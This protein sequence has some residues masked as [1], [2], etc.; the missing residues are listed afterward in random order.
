MFQPEFGPDFLFRLLRYGL[1][2]VPL[3][4][5]GCLGVL[6]PV[7]VD[8]RYIPPSPAR[9]LTGKPVFLH[10]KDERRTNALARD[11]G[12]TVSVLNKVNAVIPGGGGE[13]PGA[14]ETFVT[15]ARAAYLAAASRLESLGH[16]VLMQREEALHDAYRLVLYVYS[17]EVS[18]GDQAYSSATVG[19]AL[20]KIPDAIYLVDKPVTAERPLEE[21]SAIY[22]PICAQGVGLGTAPLAAGEKKASADISLSRALERAVNALDI[23]GCLP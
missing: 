5:A 20:G 1:L 6:S 14:E 23:K 16:P 4:L 18:F 3:A 17:F 8:V 9:E 10:L 15:P 19:L 12:F 21:K 11:A 13:S 22:A 2:A 7:T